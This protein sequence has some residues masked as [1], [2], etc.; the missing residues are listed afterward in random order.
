MN[1]RKTYIECISCSFAK[2]NEDRKDRLIRAIA[3]TA[4]AKKDQKQQYNQFGKCYKQGGVMSRININEMLGCF[5]VF[6]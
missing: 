6:L 5:D 4:V 1:R 2:K 3:T